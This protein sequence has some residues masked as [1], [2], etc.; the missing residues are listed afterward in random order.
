MKEIWK[1]ISG[2]ERYEV[3]NYG[4]VRSLWIGGKGGSYK[5]KKP[6]IKAQCLSV[7]GYPEVRL[8]QDSVS[9]KFR[10]HR[11]VAK[12]FIPNP[13]DRREV[14]H[15]DGN[16]ENNIAYNLEWA[17][18]SENMLHVFRVNKSPTMRGER[19][20]HARLTASEVQEINQMWKTGNFLQKEIALEFRIARTT[21]NAIVN[22]YTWAHLKT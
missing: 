16:K 20:G 7:W 9:K 18:R 6:I 21:V 3:S 4:R 5:R 17:T 22:G 13:S 15:K 14:N 2:W 11:L 19:N 10:T 12:A 8:C 1:K